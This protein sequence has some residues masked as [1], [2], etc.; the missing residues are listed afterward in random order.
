MS[1]NNLQLQIH[2]SK[3]NL[4]NSESKQAGN[5]VHNNQKVNNNAS[6]PVV[7]IPPVKAD[8]KKAKKSK[9]I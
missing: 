3:E 1:K 6:E 5:S 8:N 9:R 7:I 4:S 2:N